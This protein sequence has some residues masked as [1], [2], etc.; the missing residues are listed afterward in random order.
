MFCPRRDAQADRDLAVGDLAGRARV[1]P[2]NTDGVAALLQEPGVINNPR[3]DRLAV[4]HR[5]K[6]VSG[7]F[8]THVLVA[9]GR[10]AQKMQKPL[11]LSICLR[12][13]SAGQGGDGLHALALGSTQQPH[14]ISR[15]GGTPT[16]GAQHIADSSE[17]AL[18]PPGRGRIHE[19]RH[20]YI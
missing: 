3:L 19:L 12:R 2:L 17:V 11:V 10:V 4:G 13:L 20:A 8:A 16:V 9:P 1:L 14:R 18:E 7:S 15:E 6:R 5:R